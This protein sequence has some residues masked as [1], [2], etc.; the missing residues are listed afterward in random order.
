[1]DEKTG[2]ESRW[3]DGWDG[4][5]R[6]RKRGFFSAHLL[7]RMFFSPAQ[8][9]ARKLRARA[10]HTDGRFRESAPPEPMPAAS[11]PHHAA[12]APSVPSSESIATGPLLQQDYLLLGT[13]Q[14]GGLA[15][16]CER[17]ARAGD[18]ASSAHAAASTTATASRED[19]AIGGEDALLRFCYQIE[20]AR[21]RPEK[22]PVLLGSARSVH[23]VRHKPGPA[24]CVFV[25]KN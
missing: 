8:A 6:L 17:A 18:A 13:H 4:G 5:I 11:L 9:N 14:T 21:M 24:R 10:Q 15:T 7:G 16:H 1:M 2:R 22:A 23:K 12:A 20:R 25:S 3:E 19:R